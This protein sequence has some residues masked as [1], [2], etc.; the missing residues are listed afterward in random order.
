VPLANGDPSGGEGPP[1]I[2]K[3]SQI[4]AGSRDR[5]AIETALRQFAA[6]FPQL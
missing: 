2:A 4:I 3:G 1:A 6:V 5:A